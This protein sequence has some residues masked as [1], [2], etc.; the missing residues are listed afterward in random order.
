MPRF[1]K[2]TAPY[3]WMAAILFFFFV[4]LLPKEVSPNSPELFATEKLRESIVDSFAQGHWPLWNPLLGPGGSAAQIFSIVPWDYHLLLKSLLPDWDWMV[5][6]DGILMGLALLWS[7]RAMGVL[8]RAGWFAFPLA[9]LFLYTMDFVQFQAIPLYYDALF[10]AFFPILALVY[11]IEKGE[12][13]ARTWL[14]LAALYAFSFQG[15]KI[16][17]WGMQLPLAVFLWAAGLRLG[18]PRLGDLRYVGVLAF[19]WCANAW[20]IIWLRG[21]IEESGR[22]GFRGW[23]KVGPALFDFA[24][25]FP[26]SPL[27]LALF[28]YYAITSLALAQRRLALTAAPFAGIFLWKFFPVQW[29]R[30]DI[31]VPWPLHGA[32]GGLFLSLFIVQYVVLLARRRST[33]LYFDFPVLLLCASHFVF[34]NETTFN[35]GVRSIQYYSAVPLFVLAIGWLA[36]LASARTQLR[37]AALVALL[38]IYF[39]RAHLSVLTL[40]L[41]GVL[42]HNQRDTYFPSALLALLFLLGAEHLLG[43]VNWA[44]KRNQ[45]ITTLSLGT[46]GILAL[47]SFQ[48]SNF[49]R[50]DSGWAWNEFPSC[51]TRLGQVLKEERLLGPA[52]RI[53]T[54]PWAVL[55]GS[56]LPLGLHHVNIYD[57]LVSRPTKK[58]LLS[59]ARAGFFREECQ[60]PYPWLPNN[61]QRVV[62]CS[63]AERQAYYAGLISPA[64]DFRSPAELERVGANLVLTDIPAAPELTLIREMPECAGTPEHEGK[65]GLFS[66]PSPEAPFAVLHAGIASCAGF[67]AEDARALPTRSDLLQ[68]PYLKDRFD[69]AV[70]AQPGGCLRLRVAFSKFWDFSVGNRA[71]AAASSDEGF[72][73]IHVPPGQLTLAARYF[74]ALPSLFW[75]GALLQLLLWLACL[76]TFFRY[77]ENIC[78]PE[79]TPSALASD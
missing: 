10:I 23:D 7:V 60:L 32:Y 9:F 16:E 27:V 13:T 18:R 78:V 51:S 49:L 66:A 11:R 26:A 65:V 73:L 12:A 59:P 74:P 79:V 57:S 34:E 28:W 41:T 76:R 2:A 70:P 30:E 6:L 31:V 58:Y 24:Q 61:L 44:V 63:S 5:I 48:R 36:S 20:Q 42:W 52:N 72:T 45:I 56:L 21:L 69:V 47:I 39:F 75:A 43:K 3:L 50:I 1:W 68:A 33:K 62:Q 29:L 64:F 4:P 54:S 67:R 38:G 40:R 55:P 14:A 19:G 77:P 17:V 22:A 15:S 53:A 35:W 37:R 25:S 8:P 71:L 46:A